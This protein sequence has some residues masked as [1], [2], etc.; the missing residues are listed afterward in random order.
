ERAGRIQNPLRNSRRSQANRIGTSA[1]ARE[2]RTRRGAEASS[3][4][5]GCVKRESVEL[6]TEVATKTLVGDHDA[7]FDLD[8]RFRLI[9]QGHQLTNCVN[10]LFHV[11]DDQGVA[12]AINFDTATT[13]KTTLDN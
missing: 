7:H 12:A 1:G 8:L 10:I 6:N 9:E 4:T 13:R 3:T 2:R 5:G 11:R